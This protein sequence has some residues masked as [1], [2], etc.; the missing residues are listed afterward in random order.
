MLREQNEHAD[1]TQTSLQR[2][3]KHA[4]TA[5]LVALAVAFAAVLATTAVASSQCPEL[6][7]SEPPPC[8]FVTSGGFVFNNAGKEVNF[9]AHGGCKDG[10]F[11]GSVNL[12]D[13]ST[14]YHLNSV[15][16]TGYFNPTD[17]P[18]VRDIC[19]TAT[20][21]AAEPQPVY[22]HIRLIDNGE[23]G[24]ADQFGIR[25]SGGYEVTLPRLLAAGRKGGGN[26][27]LHEPNPSTTSP[28][29]MPDEATM[30]NNVAAP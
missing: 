7:P 30:C 6:C 21:N 15:D 29:P 27:Q 4:R 5:A 11:W 16:V 10:E 13:H 20:T 8:G 9:G 24:V 17:N 26:V 25:V 3:L 18:N 14:G 28:N 12:V 1:T 23:P 19:G 22:F 2:S